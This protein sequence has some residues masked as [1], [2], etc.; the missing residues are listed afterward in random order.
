MTVIFL[1][2]D[3]APKR[4]PQASV[5]GRARRSPRMDV[6]RF[7]LAQEMARCRRGHGALSLCHEV[8]SCQSALAAAGESVKRRIV[9]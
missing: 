4:K 6:L 5:R 3:H 7:D 2:Y 8:L 1:F 9:Q